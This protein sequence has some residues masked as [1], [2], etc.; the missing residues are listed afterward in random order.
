MADPKHYYCAPASRPIQITGRID[1]PEWEAAQWTDDFVDIEGDAKPA[2]RFKTRAKMM[3]DYDY[4]Y[5]AAEMQEPHVWATLTEHDSVIFQDNDF[6]VFIDPDG[7]AAAY[8][9]FEINALNTTWDLFLPQAY[10]DGGSADNSWETNALSAVH[11]K[12]TL[13]D[14][15]DIDEA[16]T[17]EIAFPWE[18]FAEGGQPIPPGEGDVWRINF[19][20]V[21]W[22]IE[23]VEGKYVKPEGC[24]EDNW[25][26]SPQ[27]VVDMHQPEQWG[28]LV[29]CDMGMYYTMFPEIEAKLRMMGEPSD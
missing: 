6:E 16:W 23:I 7:D 20:R 18:C 12:G 14:P 21:Q 11:I 27:G 13:N 29:F 28:Y 1:D 19:S 25:V 15:R 3:W 9:E 10:R 4:L 2:P 24:K 5:I 17:V 22:P 26:W 8:F